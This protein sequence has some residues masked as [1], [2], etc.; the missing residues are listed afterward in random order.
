MRDQ[1][2]DDGEDTADLDELNAELDEEITDGGHARQRATGPAGP[3]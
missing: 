1:A 2:A 3:A